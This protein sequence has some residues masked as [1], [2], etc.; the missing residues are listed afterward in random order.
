[1]S[2]KLEDKGN[3]CIMTGYACNHAGDVYRMLNLQ[4]KK[5]ICL[6]DICWLEKSYGSY[7]N[8]KGDS[9]MSVNE[10]ERDSDVES[11]DDEPVKKI[12]EKEKT[13]KRDK[14]NLDINTN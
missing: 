6:H 9:L 11:D 12:K 4:T 10:R 14:T 13:S 3:V 2:G 5:I 1:M 7:M 8:S